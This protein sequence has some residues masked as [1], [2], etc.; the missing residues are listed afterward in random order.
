MRSRFGRAAIRLG[1]AVVAVACS[2]TL[3]TEGLQTQI[4]VQLN[5]QLETT[6]I[7]VACPGDIKAESGNEF[8]CTATVPD[9]G[10]ITINVKQTD[11]DGHVTWAVV[12]GG[13]GASGPTGTT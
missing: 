3:D 12:D 1:I 11:S 5:T 9:A 13:T 8:Q 2:K 7:T 10:T 6:G 4:A